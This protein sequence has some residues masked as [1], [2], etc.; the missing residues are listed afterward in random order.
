MTHSLK[1]LVGSIILG[2]GIT[3]SS[4][5][6]SVTIRNFYTK[7]IQMYQDNDSTPI[8]SQIAA[9]SSTVPTVATFAVNFLTNSQYYIKATDGQA[10]VTN[11]TSMGYSFNLATVSRDVY[12]YSGGWLV[13]DL[14]GNPHQ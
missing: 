4:N 9:G 3:G 11:K 13:W 14:T 5:A 7:P 10:T 12:W 1:L 8:G 2:L 6:V